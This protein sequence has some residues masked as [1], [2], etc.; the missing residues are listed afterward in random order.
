MDIYP[1]LTPMTFFG[2]YPDM[3][4][5]RV[6]GAMA[7]IPIYLNSVTRMILRIVRFQPH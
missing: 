6:D 4:V 2:A 5:H 3:G 7:V 1:I